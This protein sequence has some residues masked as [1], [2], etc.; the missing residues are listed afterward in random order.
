MSLL[1]ICIRCKIEKQVE[2]FS[3]SSDKKDGLC[4]YC[5]KCVFEKAK[6]YYLENKEKFSAY[7]E[8][9]KEKIKLRNEV[10]RENN[11]ESIARYEAQYREENKEILNEKAR[12]YYNSNKLICNIR[13]RKYRENNPEKFIAINSKR[14][15]AKVKATPEWLTKE[16]FLDIEELFLCAKMF[17]LYTGQEYHVDHIVPLQGKNVCGL[18][19]LW[20]LQILPAKEN[21]SKSN[22]I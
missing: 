15:A 6:D 12:D 19:V 2:N 18:H 5:K 7:T 13:S 4:P 20:N 1:K 10:W 14:R 17:K 11:K 22:K 8:L 21:L 3:K 16:D 9:N